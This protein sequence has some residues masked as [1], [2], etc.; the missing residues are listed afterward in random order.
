V[1]HFTFVVGVGTSEWSP[2]CA[3]LFTVRNVQPAASSLSTALD[4]LP[5]LPPPNATTEIAAI[6][7]TIPRPAMPKSTYFVRWS[8]A[9]SSRCRGAWTRRGGGGV[10][11]F[12]A[13]AADRSNAPR[14]DRFR[15]LPL[16]AC[17]SPAPA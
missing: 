16:G 5:L 9:E 8:A 6:S 17:F 1:F 3:G 4:S 10:R 2:A 15:D 14:A 13:T 11:V 12:L 7:P